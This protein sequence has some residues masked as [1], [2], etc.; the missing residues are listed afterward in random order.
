MFGI[1]SMIRAITGTIVTI[2][3]EAD[4]SV[5]TLAKSN[6]VWHTSVEI[7][8]KKQVKSAVYSKAVELE[9]EIEKSK[10]QLNSIK[11]GLAEQ[12]EIELEDYFNTKNKD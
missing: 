4:K 8:H 9:K 12:L 1:P 7:N 3:S 5:S 6:E 2:F 11:P 10:N